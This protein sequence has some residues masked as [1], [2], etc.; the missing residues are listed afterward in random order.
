M[1][2]ELAAAGRLRTHKTRERPTG[3]MRIDGVRP[4][5]F[6]DTNAS[7]GREQ[8]LLIGVGSKARQD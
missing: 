6:V 7:N 1:F 8:N 3:T 2:G 4:T 5:L